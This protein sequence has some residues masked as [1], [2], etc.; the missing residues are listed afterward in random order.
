MFSPP[1][2]ILARRLPAVPGEEVVE[3]GVRA[4]TKVVVPVGV[5]GVDGEVGGGAAGAGGLRA[6]VGHGHAVGGGGREGGGSEF[7]ATGAFGG[8]LPVGAVHPGAGLEDFVG[9]IWVHIG[10]YVASFWLV[11]KEEEKES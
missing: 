9:G 10:Q 1:S 8:E 6:G 11:R 2:H 4:A 7:G 5:D 3:S